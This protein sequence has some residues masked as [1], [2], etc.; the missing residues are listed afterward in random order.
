MVDSILLN[1]LVGALSVYC[2]KAVQDCT[3]GCVING[4]FNFF[5]N[6]QF[7][8]LTLPKKNFYLQIEAVVTSDTKM[9][10][11]PVDLILA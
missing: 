8:S 4:Q 1:L 5:A 10:P 9:S 11:Y 6:Q 7:A 2:I 3:N